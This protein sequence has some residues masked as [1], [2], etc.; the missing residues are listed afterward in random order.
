MQDDDNIDDVLNFKYEE[1]YDDDD[2]D[3]EDDS[4]DENINMPISTS[5][6]QSGTTDLT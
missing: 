4:V 6:K 5:T 2:Y 1:D 3:N